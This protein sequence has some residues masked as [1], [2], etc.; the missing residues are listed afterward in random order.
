VQQE[1]TCEAAL[2]RKF[3]EPIAIAIAT[4]AQGKPNPITLGWFM[5]TSIEPQMFAIAIGLARYSLTALRSANAFVLSLPAAGMAHDA[6]YH[7]THTGRDEDKLAACGTRTQPATQVPGVLLVDAAANFE[8][9]VVSEFA[10]GDHIVFVG[11]VVVAHMH[12]DPNVRPLYSLG[13]EQMGG[14]RAA[15]R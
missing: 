10:T 6:L 13:N 15:D 7:G 8:C 3:P 5:R 9:R 1:T 2:A 14:V 4:D 12:T 11:E